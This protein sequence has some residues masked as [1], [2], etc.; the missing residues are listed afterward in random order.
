MPTRTANARW[1]GT[2]RE[3]T[4]RMHFNGF[5]GPYSFRSRFEEGEGHESGGAHRGRARRLL[6]DGARRRP[7]RGGTPA[8]E[9]RDDGRRAYRSRRW[10]VHDHP[11]RPAHGGERAGPGRCGLPAGGGSRQGRLPGLQALAGPEITLEARL[12]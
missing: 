6:L 1:E 7:H 3:G 2:L 8:G 10:R 5:D 11:Y 4:G 12:V 9:R